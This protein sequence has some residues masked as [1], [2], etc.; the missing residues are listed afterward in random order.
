MVAVD[1]T[2]HVP[3]AARLNEIRWACDWLRR[4][5]LAGFEIHFPYQLSAAIRIVGDEQ[6]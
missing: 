2:T 3:P 4:L 5:G 6:H 1:F